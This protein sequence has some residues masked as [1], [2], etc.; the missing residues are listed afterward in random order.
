MSPAQRTHTIRFIDCDSSLEVSEGETVLQSARRAGVRIVGACG[1]RGVCDS[2]AITVVSG[3]VVSVGEYAGETAPCRP[4][5]EWARACRVTPTSDCLVRIDPRALAPLGGITVKECRTVIS[6]ALKPVVRRYRAE[7]A[8]A[9][10]GDS[11]ADWDRLV[12]ALEHGA[13]ARG[14]IAALRQLSPMLRAQEWRLSVIVRNGEVIGCRPADRPLLGLAV[15]FGS[16]NAAA[17]LVDLESGLL[18][19]N[20]VMENPQGIYG[21]DV[22]TRINHAVRTET[23]SNEL[24]AAAVAA[25]E[26]FA[27][28]LC[29]VVAASPEDIVDVALCGNTAMHHLI[30]GLPVSQLGR[31]PFVPAITAALDIK[32]RD[33]GLHILE[34]A[35]V[36][37]LPNIGGF[38]GGDHVAA[39]L[40]SEPLWSRAATCL[41]M[42]IGTNTELSL[43]RHGNITTAST[44]SGP[45][46]E[47]G[48]ISA[49]MRAAQGAIERVRLGDDGL[50]LQ[51]I[52]GGEPVGLCGSGV[53]DALAALI[54]AGIV[55]KR[56]SIRPDQRY[57][58]T[59]TSL[60]E[61]ELAPNVSFTQADVRS[62]QLAKA[63]IRAGIDMLLLEAGLAEED[64]DCLVVAGAFGTVVDIPNAIT[65]G[66]LPALPPDRFHQVGNAAG[67][68]VRMALV[69]TEVREQAEELARRCRHL[70]FNT[71]PGFQKAF[72]GRIGFT[73]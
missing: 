72:M 71:L 25:L 14:D 9:T 4:V 21:S 64:L 45:A 66:M 10:L 2:C 30:L 63:A 13:I 46:L 57:V 11:A 16:T 23:G 26:T 40:A 27:R 15:D 37:A 51:V 29:A 32:A 18:L 8:P 19:A 35:Y 69:S 68:G 33:I 56:G 50:E 53:I 60:A 5:P 67:D 61:V 65:I 28:E 31:A 73:S 42:D 54:R 6:C 38:V 36:H 55:D 62:V 70:E 7:L 1:G 20:L 17:F 24:K 49:G 48:H 3:T 59:T 12:E 58:R 22:I 52:G 41:V 43:I 47:G 34:G 39:L 44:A